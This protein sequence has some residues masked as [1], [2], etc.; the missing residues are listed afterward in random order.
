MNLA[1]V[2]LLAALSTWEYPERQFRH[3]QLRRQFVT[4]VREGDTETMVETCEKGVKLLPDD[5]TWRYNLACSFAYRKDVGPAL[6]ALEKAIDLGF[7]NADAIVADND[8][9]RLANE[10][11]FGELVDYAREM[12]R[13]PLTYG[14]NAHVP[15]TGVTGGSVALGEQNF[16]WDFDNGLLVAD[17]K[18]APAGGANAGDLYMNRDDGHSVLNASAFPGLTVVRLDRDGHAARMDLDLPNMIFPYPTFGNAS[19]AFNEPK[20]WRSLPRTLMT[21]EAWKMKSFQ[22]LYLSNQFWFFPAHQDCPPVGKYGDVF[23]SMCPYF[24]V[25]AGSSYT[26]QPFLRGALEAS[27]SLRKETKEALVARGLLTPTL[28][29]LMR[30]SLKSVTNDVD[31]LTAAAHPSAFPAGSLD[32]G[33]LKKSAAALK[34]GEIPPLAPVSILGQPTVDRPAWP[35]IT[36]ASPY[37][38]AFVLRADDRV[39][40]FRLV[41]KGAEE[42]EFSVLRGAPAVKL[43]KAP[44]KGVADIEIDRSLMSVTNRVDIGVF[45]RNSGTGW[46][47]PSYVCFAVVDP[48]APYSD[49]VLTPL[50][51]VAG[52]SAGGREQPPTEGKR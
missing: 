46:G 23:A 2:L 21:R 34:P 40:R 3:E 45:G 29:T 28:M 47:A 51:P 10:P 35:E 24:W 25:S 15:Q 42:F 20:L 44:L 30:K 49:P 12:A 38:S 27:R 7:R 11:R 36:Y 26:D 33:R 13:K 9:K 5:P 6:D 50:G 1:A 14:P 16:H 18:L 4:A 31:Y 37:A 8:L 39:R 52:V 32:V 17:L 41:A 19:R 48:N 43:V 22:K